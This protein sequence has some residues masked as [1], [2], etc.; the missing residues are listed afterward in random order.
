MPI[1]EFNTTIEDILK[2][3]GIK[4]LSFSGDSIYL[5]FRDSMILTPEKPINLIPFTVSKDFSV[6]SIAGH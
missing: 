6:P 5:N 2:K 1:G 4:N 3:T